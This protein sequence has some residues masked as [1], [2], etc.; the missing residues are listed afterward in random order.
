MYRI[1][2]ADGEEKLAE[3]VTWIRKHPSGKAY[4]ICDRGK[5]EGCAVSGNFYL[6][7]DGAQIHEVDAGEAIAETKQSVIDADA[8]NVDQE[9]RLILLELGL[10]E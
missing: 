10:N 5:A 7:A 6:Y 3:R 9:Y 8:M 4:L 1:T 2:T